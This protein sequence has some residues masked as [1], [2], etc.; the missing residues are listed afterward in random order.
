MYH[1]V[2]DLPRTPF[3]RIKGMLT[4]DFRR[5]V[6]ELPRRYEMATVE[7]AL[8]IPPEKTESY[9]KAAIV[10][11]NG[12]REHAAAILHPK[13]GKPFRDA[14]GGG[15]SIIPSTLKTST[16]IILVSNPPTC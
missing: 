15:K 10:G 13:L 16:S 7:S 5:Q 8:G 4:E 1:Y 12:E 3:P 9:G 14:L 6:E 11:Q 2:R